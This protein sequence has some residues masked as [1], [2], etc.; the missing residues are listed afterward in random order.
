MNWIKDNYLT[1]TEVS[2]NK[3]K[4]RQFGFLMISILF[5]V[6]IKSVYIV[7]LFIN[8]KQLV[9]CM[10]IVLILTFILLKP[11]FFYPFLLIWIFIG[12]VLGEITSFL[13]YVITYFVFLTPIVLVMH[14]FNKKQTNKG[15]IVKNNK[16]DYT[17]LY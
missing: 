8:S 6:L 1:A 14:I 5:F 13:V 9:V 2:S 7:G 17:K 4:Q 15:W 16:V 10:L 11:L 12:A 3:K